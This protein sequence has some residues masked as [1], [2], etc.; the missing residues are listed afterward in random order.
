[1]L[2]STCSQG[3]GWLEWAQHKV[4]LAALRRGRAPNT[5]D[6][7][8]EWLVWHHLGPGAREKGSRR[9]GDI[10]IYNYLKLSTPR[11]I[12]RWCL[13]SLYRRHW[14]TELR[15]ANLAPLLQ[16]Y[17]S[18]REVT[19]SSLQNLKVRITTLSR[20]LRISTLPRAGARPQHRG[21]AQPAPGGQPRHQPQ[22][23]PRHQHLAQ[24]GRGG[25]GAGGAAREGGRGPQLVPP[26][27]WLHPQHP[28]IK[29]CLGQTFKT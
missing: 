2:V 20:Y 3:P 14:A 27:S 25:D 5:P 16:S 28:Q 11:Y 1:M 13:A 12:H 6:S 15:P 8:L 23:G 4:T 26:G 22:A 18:R 24:G 19:A 7:V 9:W 21:G 17:V 29:V 10:Y